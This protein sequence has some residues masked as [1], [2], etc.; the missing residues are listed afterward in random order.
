M[1]NKKLLALLFAGVL[2]AALDIAIIGPVLPAVRAAFQVSDR[3]LPWML[4]I[5]VLMN[6]IATPVMARLSDL[7]GR[8]WIYIS[9][10]A[11]FA[12][13]SGV[14]VLSTSYAM[15]LAGRAVQGFGA[16]GI[17]PVATA[18]IGDAFPKEKQGSALGLIG[19]VFGLAFIIGPVI[20][21]LL[22]MLGWHWVFA[23]NL[24]IAVL[25]VFFS[26]RLVPL[27]SAARTASFDWKGMS[28]LIAAL[29]ALA[30][31]INHIDVK[32]IQE[33]LFSPGVLPFLGTA[34]VLFPAFYVLERRV[35]E[36]TVNPRL[37][38]TRQLLTANLIALGAGVGEVAVLFI[39]AFAKA[40]FGLSDSAASFMLMPLVVA[41]LFGAPVAG[42]MLD[43]VG[44]RRVLLF[45]TSLLTAGL[46]LFSLAASSRTGFYCGEALIGL[47]LSAL[48]GAPLRYI[49]NRETEPHERAS[50]Q[51]VLTIFTSTGQIVSAALVGALVAGLGGGMGGLRSA[52]LSLGFL[53]VILILLT[54]RLKTRQQ[55]AES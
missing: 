49:M 44:S 47:G 34:V 19:A 39:P 32:K 41:L 6:L 21:G 43:R 37:L 33:S 12:A 26:L 20:G 7:H 50:G 1:T 30:L 5:Y 51:A 55:E 35:A 2:M 15:V 36:P 40:S 11:L 53:S 24:P 31:G 4:N 10:V 22:L 8:R 25:I 52:F 9:G 16:G 28:L 54:F 18:V 38:T 23:V 27:R 3:D 42:R 13:G 45:G 46:L 48:L 17:F 14:I 29:A